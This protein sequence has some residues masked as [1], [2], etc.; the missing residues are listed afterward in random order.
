[1]EI[2]IVLISA[3]VLRLA[4]YNLTFPFRLLA[5]PV[6]ALGRILGRIVTL[7]RNLR[8]TW[9]LRAVPRGC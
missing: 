4:W 5:T 9:T 1:M 7:P 8:H 3:A 2:A 6:V